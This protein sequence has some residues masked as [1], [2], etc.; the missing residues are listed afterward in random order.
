MT[1]YIYKFRF[2]YELAE[3]VYKYS[4]IETK[5]SIGK[6]YYGLRPNYIK[7]P[8][9]NELEFVNKIKKF[10]IKYEIVLI[11]LKNQFS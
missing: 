6:F 4:D 5:L 1:Y 8:I 7:T 9:L 10:K 2:P 11:E 3:I